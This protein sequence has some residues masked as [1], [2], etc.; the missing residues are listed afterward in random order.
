M[1]FRVHYTI[2]EFEDSVIFE[3]ETIEDIRD[4][5]CKWFTDRNIDMDKINPWSEEVE[6]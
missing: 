2:N 4:A 3:G 6:E 1:R 5:S